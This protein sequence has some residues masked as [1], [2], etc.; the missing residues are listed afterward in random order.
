LTFSFFEFE[1]LKDLFVNGFEEARDGGVPED[2]S[3]LKL[4][5]SDLVR[6]SKALENS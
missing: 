6:E 3:A 2:V 5:R 4:L 1:R